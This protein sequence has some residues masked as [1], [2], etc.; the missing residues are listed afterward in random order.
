MLRELSRKLL[1]VIPVIVPN[2][3]TVAIRRYTDIFY[4]YR[5]HRVAIVFM[6]PRT[7]VELSPILRVIPESHLLVLACAV[8]EHRRT[9]YF[10]KNFAS[11]HFFHL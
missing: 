3:I 9:E 6:L 1:Q 10:V 5:T 7:E 2:N 11:G 4:K 8:E